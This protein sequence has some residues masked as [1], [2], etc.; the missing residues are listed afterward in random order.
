M[1]ALAAVAA[2][3]VAGWWWLAAEAPT[4]DLEQAAT[5]DAAVARDTAPAA[6]GV[7]APSPAEITRPATTKSENASAA[8]PAAAP[9]PAALVGSLQVEI[10][11]AAGAPLA[12][13]PV[14]LARGGRATLEEPTDL[15]GLATF[16]AVEAGAWAIR[17][18][19]AEWPLLP[20]RAVELAADAALRERIEIPFALVEVD[21][22]VTDD[23]GRPAPNVALRARCERGGEPRGVTDHAGR[24]TIRFVKPGTVRVFAQDEHLGRGNQVLEVGALERAQVQISLRRRS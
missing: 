6:S 18:G 8:Q 22:Q 1:V 4:A 12:E 3:L 20:E 19:G 13:F 16:S 24:A 17:V 7:R 21:V 11:D 14:H 15:S 23:A 9:T 2:L 5:A 10:V